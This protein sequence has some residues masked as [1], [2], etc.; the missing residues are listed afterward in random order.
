MKVNSNTP[1]SV[2]ERSSTQKY[3][4]KYWMQ[5][6][7]GPNGLKTCRTLYPRAAE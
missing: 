7:H 3:I 4:G 5:I 1:F 2:L 6:T